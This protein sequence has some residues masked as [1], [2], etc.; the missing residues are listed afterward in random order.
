[1]RKNV[2]IFD[3]GNGSPWASYIYPH[4][5]KNKFS[6]IY[7]NTERLPT[8]KEFDSVLILNFWYNYY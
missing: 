4:P 7:K 3:C 1:M 8:Q 5:Q 6:N 2:I